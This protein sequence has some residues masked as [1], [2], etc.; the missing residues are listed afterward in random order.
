VPE[1]R[2]HMGLVLPLPVGTNLTL[3]IPRQVARAGFTS[4]Q[5]ERPIVERLLA[6]LNIKPPAPRLPAESLSGGNQQKVVLGKWLATS[7]R[8]LILDEPTAG[9]DVGAKAEVH[10]LIRTL[11]KQ[12][13]ATLLIS[14]DWPELLALSDRVLVLRGGRIVTELAHEEATQENVL[15]AALGVTEAVANAAWAREAAT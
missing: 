11:A 3:A 6:Q 13:L 9:V 15:R 8:V 5:R 14:S 2:Q 12:G 10:E 4:R 1:D 7:P